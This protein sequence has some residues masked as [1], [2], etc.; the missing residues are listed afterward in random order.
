[1]EGTLS[2]FSA[3][4]LVAIIIAATAVVVAA[5]YIRK[6]FMRIVMVGILTLVGYFMY[7][8]GFFSAENIA[9][10]KKISFTD[11]ES[12]A[13]KK[14][15]QGFDAAKG[16]DEEKIENAA[17]RFRSRTRSEIIPALNAPVPAS[18][19]AA[20][21]AAAHG[22]IHTKAPAAGA[23]AAASKKAASKTKRETPKKKES[24]VKKNQTGK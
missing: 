10:L 7:T 12:D 5:Y 18:E 21:H 16:I 14:L 20:A 2:W 9:R 17:G 8:E 19:N 13:E 1:M 23:K 22:A 15:R 24:P 6:N 3:H 4:P 11:I